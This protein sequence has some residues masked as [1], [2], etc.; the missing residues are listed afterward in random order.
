MADG[1]GTIMNMSGA[2]DQSCCDDKEVGNAEII[3]EGLIAA[4][5]EAHQIANMSGAMDQLV[6]ME[7]ETEIIEC[8]MAARVAPDRSGTPL[9]YVRKRSLESRFAR[10]N[11][12]MDGIDIGVSNVLANDDDVAETTYSAKASSKRRRVH[13]HRYNVVSS[14]TSSRP[15]K[16]K[17]A[18]N[19]F[20]EEIGRGGACVVYNGR[21]SNNTIMAIKRLNNTNNQGE[22]K[23]Q[24]EVSTKGEP[25]E[26]NRDVGLLCRRLQQHQIYNKVEMKYAISSTLTELHTEGGGFITKVG[27]GGGLEVGIGGL[28]VEKTLSIVGFDHPT[29][30]LLVRNK[31]DLEDEHTPA[32]YV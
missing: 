26:P 4:M 18:S 2:M 9:E 7:V 25:Y 20:S 30:W 23:F 17:K 32:D 31:S 15:L 5:Q 24:V 3:V 13:S 14:S 6:N 1:I 27:D 12:E 10:T 11:N 22:S 29:T 21:L 16:L 19:N 8:L 28:E